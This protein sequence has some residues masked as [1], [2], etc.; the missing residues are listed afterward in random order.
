LHFMTVQKYN[1]LNQLQRIL[2]EGLLVEA[3][4]L[5]QVGYS[6]SLRSQYVTSGW[7]VQPARGVFQR[8]AGAINWQQVVISLSLMGYPLS[9]GGL[10]ALELQGYAHYMPLGQ[11]DIH[12]YSEK[13]LPAWVDKLPISASFIQHNRSRFLPQV[14]MPARTGSLTDPLLEGVGFK[15]AALR[16]NPWGQWNW[17]LVLSTPER[18]YLE[19]LDELPARQTFHMADV[20]MESLSNLSPRRLQTL[21]EQASSI[22]VKRLFFFFAERHGHQWFS[23]II[24][25]KVEL[26]KGKRVLVKGGKL[27]TK[28]QITVPAEY[29]GA[30]NDIG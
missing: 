14:Q 22:K 7:L 13:K 2:P 21:L 15:E 10:S 20:I 5:E 3:Q 23:H 28:Y 30:S 17:P 1:K 6:R 24:Q 18:A 8:P 12:L 11:S 9:I 25:D 27:D 16:I 26:G 29:S 4:W 19:L